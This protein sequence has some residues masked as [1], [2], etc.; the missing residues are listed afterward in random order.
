LVL[1][2]FDGVRFRVVIEKIGDVLDQRGF[3]RCR[4][5]NRPRLN[6]REIVD[7]HE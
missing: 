4:R 6:A 1:F 3:G 7:W 2:P 5:V